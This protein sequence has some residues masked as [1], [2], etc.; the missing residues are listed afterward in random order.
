[1]SLAKTPAWYAAPGRL[2]L[3]GV[4]DG[5]EALVLRRAA[6]A[7]GEQG[8]AVLH[9]AQH[10]ARVAQLTESLAFFAPDIQVL[11][12]PAWDCLPYDRVSPNSDLVAKRLDTLTRLLTEAGSKAPRVILTTV[13]AITQR[14]PTRE[15][16]AQAA[17]ALKVGQR[18]D[19]KALLAFFERNGYHRT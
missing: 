1:M 3:H 2:D 8:R 17:L 5:Y 19:T 14:V 13:S 10:D 12:F 7:I 4:P 6:E 18:V 9:I 16:L 11:S 15:S